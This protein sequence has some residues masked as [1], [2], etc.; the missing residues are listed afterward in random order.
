MA[1]LI[2]LHFDG[3]PEWE[4][5]MEAMKLRMSEAAAEIVT[6]GA[7]MV[8][9]AAKAIFIRQSGQATPPTPT[10]RTGN[11]QASIK[12]TDPVDLGEGQWSAMVGPTT[13][14]GRRIELGYHGVDSLGRNYGPPNKGQ[15]PYPFLEPGMEHAT[16]DLEALANRLWAEALE[17]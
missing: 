8:G 1:D 2:A 15:P 3:L 6:Q 14:Y 16:P 11:L 12:R 9:D 7:D 4:D 13:K 5:A 10:A 17:V